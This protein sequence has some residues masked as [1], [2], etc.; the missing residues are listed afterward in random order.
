M[1]EPR[2]KVALSAMVMVIAVVVGA[3]VAAMLWLV[4]GTVGH[5]PAP[6]HWVAISCSKG[7]MYDCR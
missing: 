5:C 6:H 2:D 7:C 1:I 4:R 3:L